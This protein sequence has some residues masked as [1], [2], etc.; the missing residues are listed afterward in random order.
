MCLTL[1]TKRYGGV[2]TDPDCLWSTSMDDPLPP[3][4]VAPAA[5]PL[6]TL[7]AQVGVGRARV[8]LDGCW[9]W[10]DAQL[11]AFLGASEDAVVGEQVT[12]WLVAED[13]RAFERQLERVRAGTDPKALC[14]K[15]VR[16]DGQTG[17]LRL[18]LARAE[19]TEP[20]HEGVAVL[21]RAVGDRPARAAEPEPE[22]EPERMSDL[23]VSLLDNTTDFI[24]FKD[25]RGRFIACSQTMARVTG[26]AHWRQMVGKHDRDVFP[27][28]DAE[29]YTD[30]ELPLYNGELDRLDH[31]EPYLTPEGE[32][33]WVHTNKWPV[34]AGDRVVG[35]VGISRDVTEQRRLRAAL[36]RTDE[37]LRVAGSLSYDVSYTW[38]P[39]VDRL[40]WDEGIDAQLGLPK[41]TIGT[42]LEDWA[43][44]VHPD[45]LPQL[46]AKLDAAV[47]Q[48]AAFE[49]EYRVRHADGDDRVWWERGVP[50]AD[51]DAV[52]DRWVGVC[53]DVTAQR[54]VEAD[55]SRAFA[56]L[57]LAHDVFQYASEGIT[58]TEPDGTIVD[59]NAA[60]TE[61]TGFAREEVIGQNPSL[62][63]SGRH[64]AEFYTRMW[65]TLL[66]SGEW[67]GEVWNRRKSGEVY[68]ERL[69]IS[70]VRDDDGQLQNYVAL[71]ADITRQK[72][73][74]A[75]LRYT[76]QHDALTGLPN[77]LL[78]QDRLEQ[79]LRHA[80]RSGR[81]VAVAYLDLD[82][83]KA[84]NDTHGHAVGDELLAALATA[85]RRS[86]RAHD[87]VARIGGDEFVAVLTDL[88]AEGSVTF[89]MERL[90]RAASRPVQVGARR[91]HLS[92]SIGVSFYPQVPAVDADGLLRQADQATY[93]AKQ[94]GRDRIQVFDPT[95]HHRVQARQ[96]R[97]TALALA[98]TEDQL[99]MVYQPKVDMR[100][101][102]VMGVEGLV[103][104]A[105]PEQ[106]VL[107]PAAFVPLTEGH[108]RGIELGEWVLQRCLRDAQQ[109]RARG[110]DVPV[111]VNIS[112]HHLLHAQFVER[113]AAIR[114]SHPGAL[115][116]EIVESSQLAN[117]EAARAT[118]VACRELGV[119]IS[120]DDF[121]T[122]H[123]S[124]TWLRRLPIDDVKIDRAFV[125]DMFVDRDGRAI[126]EAT[127]GLTR[128][129][130]L[131]VVAEG[132]E[133]EALGTALL[134]LGCAVGQG[135]AIA[136]PMR[137]AVVPDWAAAWTPPDAWRGLAGD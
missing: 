25:A 43:A 122:G 56:A 97:L 1:P 117:I 30:S 104:W 27:S 108:E 54:A 84:V 126:L 121:G 113:L 58:V 65:Q 93:M 57:R 72:A 19:G 14:V 91:L 24:Y 101:G 64:D 80:D 90:R 42:R 75:D 40:D 44:Q 98:I 79:A 7:L 77:R 62:L 13:A 17:R 88:A 67:S 9:Q 32:Q 23:L 68:P 36:E 87:T 53:T 120:I 76:A 94:G 131:G 49:V 99:F 10:V 71:F 15:V 52:P 111:S 92:A 35:L 48:G 106:G 107:L 119:R 70:A 41:G 100:T 46:K 116:L 26:H 3:A 130:E 20:A 18:A 59:V 16:A 133:S 2:K 110:L 115:E 134:D 47:S 74:E 22:R 45:D 105:H 8:D 137:A 37:R 55:K 109:W 132:V 118:L 6:A 89:E 114:A 127:L 123:A 63:K 60:F 83:F 73:H 69:T 50:V 82:G 38:W 12:T 61:I 103:R 51:G 5:M 66:D 11:C 31:V 112:P 29:R 124:L 135:F 125:A 95:A 85:L 4:S 129:F 78:L 33:R 96:Q 128:A 21:A 102:Q 28:D 86:V 39:A 136:R 81:R 34:H